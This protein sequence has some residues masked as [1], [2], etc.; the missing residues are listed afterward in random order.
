MNLKI[1]NGFSNLLW[2]WTLIIIPIAL[3]SP[4]TLLSF[5][6]VIKPMLGSVILAMGLTLS[7]SNFREVFKRPFLVI[8]GL[9]SQYS[10][11]PIAGLFVGIIFF[12][13]SKIF[14]SEYIAGQILTGSCPTGVVSN[15][16]N[17][18]A[19]ANVALSICLSAINTFLAPFLTPFITRVLA[20]K[21]IHVDI[22]K[23]FIDMIEV[24]LLPVLIGLIIN[25]Y[26]PD[27]I[28]KIKSF[29]PIYSTIS[30]VIIIGYVVAAG[31]LKILHLGII[32]VLLLVLG[33]IV[34][35]M[36]GYVL[37]FSIAKLF[38]LNNFNSVTISIE[39]AMQNSGLATVLALSQWGPISAL[40]A[41]IY[42]VVQN[43]IGPFVCNF[44]NIKIVKYG[45]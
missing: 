18:L 31:R 33:S 9:I 41:I 44:F 27:K 7:I 21:F 16:Y 24:T 15:V 45:S 5:K 1:I 13:V 32:Q 2:L 12:K 4:L 26:F 28:K 39:T 20:G 38:R 22:L 8:L 30:V 40:P 43:I 37:G 11:M 23:L 36:I 42:S 17:F 14:S 35:L 25:T 34:H 29:F 6:C 10:I 19:Q 3:F